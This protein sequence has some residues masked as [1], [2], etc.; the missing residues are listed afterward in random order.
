MYAKNF[1]ATAET[2]IDASPPDVWD[3]FVNPDTIKQYMFGTTVITDWKVGSPIVW[4]GE[5]K[6]KPYEDK[7]IITDFIPF[8]RLQYTHFS[9]MTGEQDKPENYHTITITFTAQQNQTKVLLEQDNNTTQ[10]AQQHAE[11]NWNAMLAAVKKLF[12]KGEV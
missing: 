10:A 3:A 4:K 9:P 11:E 6:G 8:T 1:I 7:G 12:A 5:W 2:T